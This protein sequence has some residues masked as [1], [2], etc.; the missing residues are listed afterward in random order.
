MVAIMD[1]NVIMVVDRA[2]NARRM[3]EIIGRLEAFPKVP[4]P[5]PPRAP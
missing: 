2:S 4:I 1:R 5:E 3:V